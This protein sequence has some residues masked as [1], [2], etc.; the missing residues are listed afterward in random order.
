[1]TNLLS[2][3][4]NYLAILIAAVVVMGIGF[5]WYSDMLFGK[6]WRKESKM[7]MS[8]PK[9]NGQAM[10]LMFAPNFIASVVMFYVLAIMIYW[11][12]DVGAY[13]GMLTG[14][15][16]WFG[17]IATTQLNGILFEKQTVTYYLIN[18]CFH[19]VSFAVAGAIIGA[20]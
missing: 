7:D 5:L 10:F 2:L 6:L 1:M 18:T 20:W 17:F 12:G 11:A 8:L 9:P 14:I 15:L 16:V 4:I 19:L 13:Q 3:N